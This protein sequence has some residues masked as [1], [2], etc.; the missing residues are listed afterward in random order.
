MVIGLWLLNGI[1]WT[2]VAKLH[3]NDK[4]KLLYG[5]YPENPLFDIDMHNLYLA[6]MPDYPSNTTTLNEKD[7]EL[8][9][10]RN[11]ERWLELEATREDLEELYWREGIINP[12]E[13]I[14]VE[15]SPLIVGDPEDRQRFEDIKD[16]ALL[17]GIFNSKPLEDG[18][19]RDLYKAWFMMK[20]CSD[21]GAEKLI[22]EGIKPWEF[23]FDL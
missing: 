23:D 6:K 18:G 16:K 17:E 11:F 13:I 15:G 14:W 9:I 7:E 19:L 12:Q 22:E 21:F 3:A 10:K 2:A 4:K 20:G 1:V 8:L 5:P